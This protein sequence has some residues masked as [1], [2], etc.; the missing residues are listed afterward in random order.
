MGDAVL[1]RNVCFVEVSSSTGIEPI[2][3]YMVQ[4]LQKGI[5]SA[6]SGSGEFLGLLSGRGGTQVDVILYLISNGKTQVTSTWEAAD[7]D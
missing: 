1:E 7:M 6:S 5:M 4:Q 2:L 3:E